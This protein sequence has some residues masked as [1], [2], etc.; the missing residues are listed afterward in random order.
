MIADP[1]P[2]ATRPRMYRSTLVAF[3]LVLCAHAAIAWWLLGAKFNLK[4]TSLE[5]PIFVMVVSDGVDDP[6]GDAT[7]PEG[8]TSAQAEHAP[9]SPVAPQT[10]QSQPARVPAEPLPGSAPAQS[11]AEPVAIAVDKSVQNPVNNSV[12]KPDLSL[13]A[14]APRA[15]PPSGKKPVRAPNGAAKSL[16]QP[17]P[18]PTM[19]TGTADSNPVGSTQASVATT[20]VGNVATTAIGNAATTAT[21]NAATTAGG[22]SAGSTGATGGPRR[23]VRPDYLDGPPAPSYPQSARSRRQ[24]GKVIVR[25]VISP[26][27][28]PSSIDV[29][30]P[31]GF[32]VL[33]RAALDAVRR[34]RFRPYAENGV[35]LE[36]LV[37]IPFDFVL[38]N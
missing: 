34:A 2:P 33:D 23:I 15:A 24:Q 14:Q 10:E 19:T 28:Q 11:T 38:R 17:V 9:G 13:G 35:A 20:A 7:N 5:E 31:S 16:T 26:T 22:N 21:G 12:D 32:D 25:V 6:G 37:D 3:A 18:D 1:V 4:P 30:Q 27:G 8:A 29:L 36:A